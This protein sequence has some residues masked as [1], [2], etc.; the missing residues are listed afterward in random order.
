MGTPSTVEA[1]T[2]VLVAPPTVM[3]ILHSTDDVPH[4]VEHPPQDQTFAA[5]PDILHST[6]HSQR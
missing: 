3:R 6:A 1:L 2:K 5:E 4:N